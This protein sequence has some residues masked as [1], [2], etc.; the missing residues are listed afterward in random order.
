MGYLNYDEHPF[1]RIK[2]LSKPIDLEMRRLLDASGPEAL[3]VFAVIVWP[4]MTHGSANKAIS[5]SRIIV[6]LFI[7]VQATKETNR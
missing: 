1:Q 5:I 7:N 4:H 3:I 2:R 6:L